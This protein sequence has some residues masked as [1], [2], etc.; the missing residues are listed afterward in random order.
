M[1]VLILSIT[2]GYGHHATAKAMADELTAR[3]AEVAV[4]DLLE[5]TSKLLFDTVD[6]GYLFSTKYAS[7]FYRRA[8]DALDE[9]SH[10]SLITAFSD[11]ILRRFAKFFNGFTP[12][13][14]VC[15]HPFAAM[16]VNELKQSGQLNVP[17][18]GIV[19]DYTIHPF[20]GDMPM[21]EYMVVASDLLTYLAEKKGIDR[22]RVLPFGIP[23]SPKFTKSIAAQEARRELGL[24]AQRRTL[25]VMSGSMGYGNVV[26]LISRID[27]VASDL[28]I[29]C[30]CGRNDK[31]QAKLSRL[32]TTNPIKIYGFIDNIDLY[33]D[34]ADCIITKPGGLTITEAMAK[35][36]PMILVNPIPG[37]EERN[38]DFLLNNGAAIKVSKT[39]SIEESMYFLFSNLERP[40]LMRKSIALIARSNA[41][42]RLCDFI[43]EL[44]T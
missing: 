33:M 22:S 5:Y 8:Y 26:Q 7:M 12:D 43:M 23:I 24:D 16:A 27:A 20:W 21:V 39:F 37:Q 1:R 19:T 32:Q 11:V 34:A 31:L 9:N 25:L 30:V 10:K 6:K 35:K 4:V 41:T 28:Q 42:T 15:T 13:A 18:I 3:G 2:T 36:L 40:E 17:V 38:S 29:V 44:G 14:I